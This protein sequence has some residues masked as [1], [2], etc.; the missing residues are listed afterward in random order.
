VRRLATTLAKLRC[1]LTL[2]FI[3]RQPLRHCARAILRS[4]AGR[5]G[6]TR[7]RWATNVG[8]LHEGRSNHMIPALPEKRGR[9]A[10]KNSIVIAVLCAAALSCVSTATTVLNPSLRRPPISPDRVIIYTSPDKVPGKYD[11]VAVLTSQ[12]DYTIAGDDKFYE[13]FRQEAAKIGANGVIISPIEDPTTGQKVGSAILSAFLIPT[14]MANRKIQALAIYVTTP[15]DDIAK[16]QEAK[17]KVEQATRIETLDVVVHPGMS[18]KELFGAVSPPTTSVVEV[19]RS[20]DVKE[21]ATYVGANGKAFIVTLHQ[22]VV[23]DVAT[24]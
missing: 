24:K 14:T 4:R 16:A 23:T 8:R 5:A 7:I 18:R 13:S 3:G 10:L 6:E 15:A 9:S 17:A 20:G 2:L 1:R 21:T 19:T 11:E 22:N 12:G